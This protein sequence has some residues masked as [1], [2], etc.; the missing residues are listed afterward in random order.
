[1]ENGKVIKMAIREEYACSSPSV[2]IEQT[3]TRILKVP[4]PEVKEATHKRRKLTA[5]Y[6]LRILKE[7][8]LCK[9]DKEKNLPLLL[10][11]I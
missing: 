5:E 4:N 10:K 9:G 2:D 8:D 3:G 11:A 6:K 7:T 1:V